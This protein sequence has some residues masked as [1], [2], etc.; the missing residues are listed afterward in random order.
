MQDKVNV[1]LQTDLDLLVKEDPVLDQLIATFPEQTAS[2][3]TKLRDQ[4]LGKN[5]KRES[6][7]IQDR[8]VPDRLPV[9]KS[10]VILPQTENGEATFYAQ[11]TYKNFF[12]SDPSKRAEPSLRFGEMPVFTDSILYPGQQ[13]RLLSTTHETF[14]PKSIPVVEQAKPAPPTLRM[15]GER[16]L[17]TTNRSAFTKKTT[18]TPATRRFRT[19]DKGR[20]QQEQ[21]LEQQQGKGIRCRNPF[22]GETQFRADFPEDRAWVSVQPEYACAP[23]PI[24]P[25]PSEIWL[26]D[27][28][29]H[30]FRTEQRD[31]YVVRDPLT[32]SVQKS[33]KKEVPPYTRPVIK[34][35]DKTVTKSDFPAYTLDQL[36][37][38]NPGKG[39][40][41]GSLLPTGTPWRLRTGQ[42]ETDEARQ[43]KEYLI[44]L[45]T[46]KQSKIPR[47]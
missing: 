41:N 10:R 36:Q 46:A 20:V 3:L 32:I 2:F 19:N 35:A 21:L 13:R 24:V 5:D 39:K 26:R 12:G 25:P 37:A 29:L 22:V 45:Q 44:E 30:E 1:T 11:T 40:P 47:C 43:L 18:D 33:C 38:A 23:A 27:S 14:I 17:E 6:E 7:R 8:T 4:K 28:D 15:E 16:Y 34:F 31:Q 9:P 42:L